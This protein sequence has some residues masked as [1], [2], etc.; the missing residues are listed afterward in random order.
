MTYSVPVVFEGAAALRASLVLSG[1]PAVAAQQAREITR[2]GPAH[3]N[4]LLVLAG[5]PAA[6]LPASRL[7]A[8]LG[9]F[10]LDDVGRLDATGGAAMFVRRRSD[11]GRGGE[12]VFA[13]ELGGAEFTARRLQRLGAVDLGLVT[14]LLVADDGVADDPDALTTGAPFSLFQVFAG[15]LYR[16][17]TMTPSPG[18]DGVLTATA[19][20]RRGINRAA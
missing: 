10:S 3:R 18:V 20:G 15:A 5:D 2:A 12:P 7:V 1:D 13:P 4:G 11:A 9:E 6:D 19:T 16:V 14:F 8:P 17:A